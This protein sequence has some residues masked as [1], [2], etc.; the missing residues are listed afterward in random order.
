MEPILKAPQNTA[1]SANRSTTAS[2]SRRDGD[3]VALNFR[4]G[5]QA[6][7][8]TAVDLAEPTAPGHPRIPH[9]ARRRFCSIAAAAHPPD[10]VGWG[11]LNRFLRIA[12]PDTRITTVELDGEVLAVAKKYMA[13]RPDDR[14]KVAIEDGRSVE[15]TPEKWD[16]IIVD[17]FRDG[18]VPCI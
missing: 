2:W 6:R 9:H 10:R 17:A 3:I 1:S 5:R 12:Y 4:V 16:W 15:K 18:S 8:Q 11:G 13:Y 14:D 7:R